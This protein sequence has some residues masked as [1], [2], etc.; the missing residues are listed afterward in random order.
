MEKMD[1]RKNNPGK[2]SITKIGEHILSGSLMSTIL[3]FKDLGNKHDVYGDKDCIKTF[4][5]SLESKQ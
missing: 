4:C 2:L 3:P 5:E 1:G